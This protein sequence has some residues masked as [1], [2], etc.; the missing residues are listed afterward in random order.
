MRAPAC[1]LT[2][3]LALV[4]AP[5]LPGQSAAPRVDA[6]IPVMCEVMLQQIVSRDPAMLAALPDRRL[7]QAAVCSC[8]NERFVKD[9]EISRLAGKP[10][11]QL[12]KET[13]DQ[14]ARELLSSYLALRAVQHIMGCFSDELE[15]GLREV[16]LK[17]GA[18]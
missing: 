14:A 11:D 3:C 16:E 8:A 15:R 17:T 7:D 9:R 13:P 5:A 18:Q 6:M 1:L 12:V 10:V 2:F 4:A